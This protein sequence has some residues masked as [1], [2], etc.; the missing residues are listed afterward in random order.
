MPTETEEND[1]KPADEQTVRTWPFADRNDPLTI[2]FAPDPSENSGK[3]AAFCDR[4]KTLAPRITVK[5]ESDP[6][7]QP[8]FLMVGESGNVIYRA[9]PAGKILNRFIEALDRVGA[10]HRSVAGPDASLLERIDL[11]VTIKLYVAGQCPHCPTVIDQLQAAAAA[12][13]AIQLSIIDAPAF[14]DM[15]GEDAVRSVPT[16]IL[17]DQFR[18]SGQIDLHELATM[19]IQR[20]PADLSAASLRRLIE[21]GDA[22]RVASMMAESGRIFPALVELLTHPRWSVRLGA[23]VTVEY[24]AEETPNLAISLGDLLWQDFGRFSE[25]VQVDVLHLFGEIP[26]PDNRS[27]LA[28]IASGPYADSVRETA[29]EVLEEIDAG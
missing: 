9:V 23:M 19:C 7:L 17:D 2:T 25:Q 21:D 29:E 5:K 16:I 15:A 12:Q 3:M 20:D 24:L 10:G 8:P 26:S 13:P 28:G 11:P 14:P 22:E 1:V 18:W 4:I 27:R 6:S